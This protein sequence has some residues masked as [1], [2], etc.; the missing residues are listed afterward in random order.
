MEKGYV[1]VSKKMER[2]LLIKINDTL[3]ITIK[4]QWRKIDKLLIKELSQKKRK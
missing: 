1:I 3:W 2:V 4:L